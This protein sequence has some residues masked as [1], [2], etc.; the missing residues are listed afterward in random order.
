MVLAVSCA[1]TAEAQWIPLRARFT[2]APEPVA[3]TLPAPQVV[4]APKV[5]PGAAPAAPPPQNGTARPGYALPDAPAAPALPS[6]GNMNVPLERLPA[7]GADPP[8]P[9]PD[10]VGDVPDS[11]VP[12]WHT[13]V[14]APLRPLEPPLALSLDNALLGTLVHSP[15]VR[16]IADTPLIRRAQVCEQQAAFDFKT[17]LDSKFTDTSDPV[18]NIL[19]TGGAPRY[20]DQYWTYSGGVRRVNPSG[21][22]FELS[23]KFGYQDNNSIFFVP[24]PQGTARLNL[25]L[26]Q[27]LLRGAG[28]TYNESLIVLAQI[29]TGVARDQLSLDLQDL[30]LGVHRAYWDLYLQR[31]GLVQRRRLR[32]SSV[33]ILDELHGRRDV[34]V[35]GNQ[36]VRAR[37]A[38][39][40]REA[41]IIRFET[42]VRNA[43]ARLRALIND[44]Q[45]RAGPMQELIPNQ[46]LVRD[47]RP[48][49]LQPTLTAALDTRP[50]ITQALKQLKASSVRL[51]VS[52]NE[53]LPS[54]NLILGTYVSG[55][56]GGGSIGTGWVDQWT[57]GRPTYTTGMVFEVPIGNRAA[58]ARWQQRQLE[59]R[60][61]TSQLEATVAQARAQVEIA[62]REVST[63][64]REMIARY[65]AMQADAAEVDYLTDRWRSLP[66]DQQ[67]AGVVLD[68]L[69]SAQDRLADAEL[70]FATATVS[71]NVALANL[72]RATGTLLNTEDVRE[73]EVSNGGLPTLILDKSNTHAPAAAVPSSV[74]PPAAVP[75]ATTA[76]LPA[77]SVPEDRSAR[78]TDRTFA[79]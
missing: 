19:T 55:L 63:T 29:E 46:T 38:V 53:L 40:N 4:P 77:V 78:R 25:G 70:G 23:Q 21:G 66:G 65:H 37:A 51:G 26:T 18:G 75:S 14:V 62:V 33:T 42:E 22:Q 67:V 31:A 36:L 11:Y 15:Q 9:Q 34:D 7:V 27:P 58:K 59:L 41:A 13:I 1:M 3:P 5:P 47:F 68:N 16:V 6:P 44:P 35:L 24:L 72:Q 52:K 43:E 30:L 74:T 10:I 2:R 17:F 71:Y 64:H 8:A 49:E 79:R 69:L 56:A 45:F 60:Q 76:P 54:L 48:V 32:E 12:W 57:M 28:R 73:A 50:D 61:L 39:A 20:I